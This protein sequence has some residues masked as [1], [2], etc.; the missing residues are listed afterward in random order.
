MM[1]PRESSERMAEWEGIA[2]R[3]LLDPHASY[4]E[5]ST[6]LVGITRSKDTLLKEKLETKK[7]TAWKA[8]TN[9]IE[10]LSH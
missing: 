10:K 8:D 9:V 4:S 1:S 2:R 7:T 3:I 6:A 5:V